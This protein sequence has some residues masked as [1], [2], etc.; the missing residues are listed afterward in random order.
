[1]RLS[2]GEFYVNRLIESRDLRNDVNWKLSNNSYIFF[3][4]LNKIL[5]GKY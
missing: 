5:F 3:F 1:M 4:H 2:I